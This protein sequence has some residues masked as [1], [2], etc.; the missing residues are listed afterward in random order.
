MLVA[1]LYAANESGGT[2]ALRLWKFR[3]GR[4]AYCVGGRWMGI[5]IE[6]PTKR[7]V[8]KASQVLQQ[9]SG[10]AA[11]R[12]GLCVTART[13][14]SVRVKIKDISIALLKSCWASLWVVLVCLWPL[15][16]W[17]AAI[18][19]SFQLIRT[20]YYWNNPSVFAGWTFLLHFASF[21]ALTCVVVHRPAGFRD[22]S[23]ARLSE[24]KARPAPAIT[25]LLLDHH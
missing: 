8:A 22:S 4:C 19:L 15:V 18:D 1:L 23:L 11:G 21:T 25:N 6:F 7:D 24:K 20:A 3:F 13:R 17:L 5:V 14:F 10:V 2:D 16:R 9:V 12:R